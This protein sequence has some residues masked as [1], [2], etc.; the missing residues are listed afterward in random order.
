M[1]FSCRN[2]IKREV[3]QTASSL[4]NTLNKGKFFPKG[5]WNVSDTKVGF[6]LLINHISG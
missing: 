1:L 2:L 5:T 3:N 4:E 6:T